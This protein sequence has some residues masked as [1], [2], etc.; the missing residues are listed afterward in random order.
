MSEQTARRVA[1]Q[2]HLR[3]ERLQ[4]F[5]LRLRPQ[6]MAEGDLDLL[7]VEIAVEI[8]EIRFEQ[9]LGRIEAGPHAE[10]GR[11]LEFPP[12]GDHASGHGVYA[13]SGAQ[14]ILEAQVGRRVADRAADL[15]AVADH[16]ANGKRAAE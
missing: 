11:A 7:P 6:E 9:L 15:V 1:I 3:G 14:V 8:E 5:E 12:G 13:E 10:V 4:G 16:A 2:R